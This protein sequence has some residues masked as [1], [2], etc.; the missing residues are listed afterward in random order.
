MGI[1]IFKSSA[2]LLRNFCY[3][4]GDPTFRYFLSSEGC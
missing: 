4:K 1:V 3:S 2:E